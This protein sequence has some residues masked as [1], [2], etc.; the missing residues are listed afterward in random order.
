MIESS[1]SPFARRAYFYI[2]QRYSVIPIAPG[3]KRPGSFSRSKGWEGMLDW[4][5]FGGR[6][7][8]DIELT[9]WDE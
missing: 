4:E 8:S 1:K 2:E 5:R 7:A 3:T 6:V 9:H